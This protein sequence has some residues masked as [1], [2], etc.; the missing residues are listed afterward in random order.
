MAIAAAAIA[1]MLYFLSTDLAN[2]LL[3]LLRPLG[4][5]SGDVLRFIAYTDTQRA[6]GTAIDPNLGDEVKVT[7]IATGF[8]V[9]EMRVVQEDR[10]RADL[11]V[12]H[13]QSLR[14]GRYQTRGSVPISSLR[15][16]P[17]SRRR[18][19]A[20]RRISSPFEIASSRR[21]PK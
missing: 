12:E 20:S 5:P 11:G 13:P 1:L 8:T 3:S 21:S 9:P 16:N 7:V 18:V 19:S 15:R 6:I 14:A 2:R 4:Y 10:I 17:C